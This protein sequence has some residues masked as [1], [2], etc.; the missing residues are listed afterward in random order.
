MEHGQAGVRMRRLA[1]NPDT[2]DVPPGP[3]RAAAALTVAVSYTDLR[4]IAQDRVIGDIAT[5]A[6]GRAGG[7]RRSAVGVGV[8]G[9]LLFVLV[10]ALSTVVGR[11]ISQPLR[12]LSRAAGMVAHLAGAELTRVGD[13]DEAAT[14]PRRLATIEVHSVDEVGE[15]AAVLNRVQATTA[16]MLE[17][18]VTSRRNVAVMF[19]NIAR[20]TQNLVGRQLMLIDELERTEQ[21]AGLLER[22][23]RLDHVATRL[24]RSADALLVVSGTRDDSTDERPVAL[25]DVV[26]SAVAEIEGYRSVRLRAIHPVT[27]D[28]D[29]V[30]DLRL[31]LAELLEN[32]TSFSPPGTLVD[33]FAE[34]DDG[35]ECIVS[36]VDHGIGMSSARLAEE[37]RRLVDRERLDVAPTTVLGLFVVGRLARRH[38]LA[39]RLA[40]TPGQGVT[41]S[42]TIP[43]RLLARDPVPAGPARPVPVAIEAPRPA[44][45]TLV[46][47]L[48]RPAD[49]FAWFAR[50]R[51]RSAIELPAGPAP[52]A[53]RVDD[54]PGTAVVVDRPSAPPARTG[55]TRG[56]LTRR[57]PGRHLPA[58]P[59]VPSPPPDAPVRRRDADAE[60]AELDDFL[61]GLA[62]AQP[63][64]PDTGDQP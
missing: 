26:R 17:R 54:E 40:A 47:A 55:P 49:Q 44:V 56:G 11:S 60:R 50:Q 14:A 5:A 48:D 10:V 22:L 51:T 23:Y 63:T 13:S 28:V 53:A 27:V 15:L 61:D 37:N 3:A 30:G 8:S 52:E 46:A 29:L 58:L 7:A 6:Q 18:Q 16:L 33:V 57:S 39:V 12:R 45:G 36:V 34:L 31:L 21:D 4:L 24:R 35:D 2:P 42:V 62:R 32:A 59:D 19:A 20:R 64:S 38:G 9:L 25:A 41:A 43:A 1:A